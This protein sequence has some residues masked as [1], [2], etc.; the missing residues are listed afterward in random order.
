MVVIAII[1]ILIALLLPAVQ[2]AR[3]A[4]R[5]MQCSNNLKQLSI[6]LQNY[7][8]SYSAFPAR[9]SIIQEH[10]NPG[11]SNRHDVYW[12]WLFK[13]LPFF[14]QQTR[15]DAFVNCSPN[16]C[17]PWMT[18]E[19]GPS[20][21]PVAIL[22]GQ[23]STC[24]CPS[25]G[26]ASAFVYPGT[27][28]RACIADHMWKYT[29]GW[30]VSNEGNPQ[31][32]VFVIMQWRDMG[33]LT[34]GTSNTICVSESCVNAD[35]TGRQVKGGVVPVVSSPDNGN[36]GGPVGKC[37]LMK[38]SSGGVY[39]VTN[40]V[41]LTK[42]T[43]YNSNRNGGRYHDGRPIYSA[44]HTVLPPNSPSCSH[45]SSAESNNG[46]GIY[47]ASSFHTGGVNAAAFDG[48]VRFISETINCGNGAAGEPSSGPSPYGVWGALGTADGG[49]SNA[50]L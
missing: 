38:L 49:E 32:S 19:A 16:N 34:D 46:C 26:G 41:N 31:R 21:V 48:S 33:F 44:F 2:A 20:P 13:V 36:N 12:S 3:E 50:N 18:G 4:A 5:R 29:S 17:S 22:R 37:G 45:D 6:A 43:E 11:A 15:Y 7:H 39:T 10:D 23:L 24:T 1:G 9:Q 25:D 8:D 27:N 30:G 47:S 35:S 40:F 28:Y 42:S 14:E